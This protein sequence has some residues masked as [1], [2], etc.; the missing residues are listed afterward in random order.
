MASSPQRSSDITLDA[1][2]RLPA[3]IFLISLPLS[4]LS[5]W[6]TVVLALFAAFL[7]V[8]TATLH[9]VFT[10]TALEVYRGEVRIRQF[11][12]Q[13][14]QYWEIYFSWIPILFYFREVKSIHFLPI[15]FDPTQLQTCLETRV[16]LA[17]LLVQSRSE[18]SEQPEAPSSPPE[19][20]HEPNR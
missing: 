1:S 12:Y 17:S 18:A 10:A 5:P 16:G 4:F 6:A 11:P 14:W 7:T 15:L 2:Y 13:E 3:S 19:P 9:L 8:Q 20:A